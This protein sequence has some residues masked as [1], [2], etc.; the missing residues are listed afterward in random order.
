MNNKKRIETLE[1]CQIKEAEKRIKLYYKQKNWIESNKNR[2]KN[3]DRQI[4]SIEDDIKNCNVR[5]G[6]D[7]KAIDYS[8]E[9]IS[10]G[11]YAGGL[12]EKI[13][14]EINK[15]EREVLQLVAEKLELQKHNRELQREID[16]IEYNLDTLNEEAKKFIE[17]RYREGKTLTWIAVEMYQGI[18]ITTKRA[19]KKILKSIY[20]MLSFQNMICL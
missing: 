20:K 5:I 8:K 10:G 14:D 3:I 18:E 17:Y 16:K 4:S 6:V 12:E 19:K 15:M 11:F 9:K 13:I 7:L 2:I 1:D